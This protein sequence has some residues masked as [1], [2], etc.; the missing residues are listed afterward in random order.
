MH[1][2]LNPTFG[3]WMDVERRILLSP[4]HS[5][6]LGYTKHEREAAALKR[7]HNHIE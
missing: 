6:G 3:R 5:H 1:S 7:S 2:A 4:D